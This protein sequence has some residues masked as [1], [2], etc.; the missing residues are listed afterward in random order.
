MPSSGV[1]SLDPDRILP[2]EL[3]GHDLVEAVRANPGSEYVVTV[4]EDVLGVLR[5]A[6]VIQVLESREPSR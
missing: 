5:V 1:D 6:D 3:S 4:G 2:A